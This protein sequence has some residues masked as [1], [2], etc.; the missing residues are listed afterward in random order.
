MAL[1]EIFEDTIEKVEVA[2]TFSGFDCPPEEITS[3]L[4]IQPDQLR[5]KG[6]IL[7]L[8]GDREFR[9]PE[10][11]WALNSR[12]SSKDLNVQVRDILGRLAGLEKVIEP[13]WNPA[14]NVFWK[15]TILGAGAGPYFERD[16]I[17]GIARI[18]AEVWQD[19]WL[20]EEG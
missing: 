3:I 7:T 1:N 16:V 14:F 13:A 12:E 18:G 11:L 9:A 5:T 10:S 15:S 20:A 2:L 8:A 19:L 17:E 4:G 6:E